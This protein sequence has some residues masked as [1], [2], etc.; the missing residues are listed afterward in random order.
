MQV[1][2]QVVVDVVG[3]VMD[4]VGVDYQFV[5]DDFCVGGCFFQ[6]VDKEMGS[7]YVDGFKNGVFRWGV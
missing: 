2:W 7:F 5:V 4:Y 1:D 3:D 6:G